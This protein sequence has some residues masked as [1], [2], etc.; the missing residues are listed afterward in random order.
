[1]NRWLYFTMA[2]VAAVI[3]GFSVLPYGWAHL[4]VAAF[5]AASSALTGYAGIAAKGKGNAP[6]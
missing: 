4:T 1:M 5:M 3:A 6:G 2:V